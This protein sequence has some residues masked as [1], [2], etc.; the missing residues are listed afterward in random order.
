MAPTKRVVTSVQPSPVPVATLQADMDNRDKV[1]FVALPVNLYEITLPSGDVDGPNIGW[2]SNGNPIIDP[3]TWLALGYD[4]VRYRG[5]GVGVT[6]MRASGWDGN[7][8]SI[9]RHGGIVQFENMTIHCGYNKAIVAGEQN[10]GRVREPKFQIRLIGCRIETDEPFEYWVREDKVRID[11]SNRGTGYAVNDILT[12]TT[13]TFSVAAQV[14]VTAVNG[15]GGVTQVVKQT[16]GSYTVNPV[17]GAG[18][19]P[20]GGSGTGVK[21][22]LGARPYWGGFSYNCDVYL[23]QTTIACKDNVEHG[24]YC[25]GF[26]RWG[27][28]VDTLT[29]E[30][31]GAEGFKVRSDATETAWAGN[32]QMILIKDST[33]QD[34]FQPWS[35]RGGG[36]I[37]IQG[38]ACNIIIQDTVLHGGDFASGGGIY[39]DVMAHE[40]S[41]CIALSSEGL[42]Y[43]HGTG[44]VPKPPGYPQTYPDPTYHYGNGHVWIHRVTAYAPNNTANYSNVFRCARNGG[45]QQSARTITIQACGFWGAQTFVSFGNY[46]EGTVNVFGCNTPNLIAY[47]QSLGIDTS[48]ESLINPG[49]GG[50]PL[51]PASTGGTY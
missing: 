34:W 39:P 8:I 43:D 9:G 19:S 31:A 4:G 14:K 5:Q 3:Q 28:V 27:A 12:F 38:S 29:V 40:R 42:S 21:M 6:H 17:F 15:V 10:T 23:Y 18:D 49:P 24:W 50:G 47:A 22:D 51:V 26:A 37:V 35:F 41:K 33:F 2:F 16:V 1:G 13:G 7:C 32:K 48:V 25:H 20:T 44:F 36:G 30:S 45:S 11:G 46:D